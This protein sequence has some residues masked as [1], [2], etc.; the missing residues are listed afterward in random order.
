MTR[1]RES[2]RLSLDVAPR[3]GFELL[4]QRRLKPADILNS[5]RMARRRES[6]RLSGERVPSH[7]TPAADVNGNTVFLNL[8]V[9]DHVEHTADNQLG[10]IFVKI[11]RSRTRQVS[12]L[13]VFIRRVSVLEL[14]Q[15]GLNRKPH[16]VTRLLPDQIAVLVPVCTQH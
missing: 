12:S 3:Y 11:F 16:F 2:R 6:R 15:D 7:I 13:L 8:T 14:R 4:I 5:V 1:R 10:P 9:S